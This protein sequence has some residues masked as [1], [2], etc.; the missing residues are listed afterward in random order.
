MNTIVEPKPLNYESD[1]DR[2]FDTGKSPKDRYPLRVGSLRSQ[3]CFQRVRD[4]I[5]PFKVRQGVK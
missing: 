1:T 2:D 4:K 3:R 5:P